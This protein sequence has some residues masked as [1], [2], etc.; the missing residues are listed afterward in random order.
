LQ[1]KAE[2]MHT[3]NYIQSNKN[4]YTVQYEEKIKNKMYVYF[5]LCRISNHVFLYVL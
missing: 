1:L 4:H 2:L 3:K 5:T